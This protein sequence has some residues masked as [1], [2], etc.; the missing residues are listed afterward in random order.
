MILTIFPDR[1]FNDHRTPPQTCA[2]LGI[3]MPSPL[4]VLHR[5]HG[6]H[7]DGVRQLYGFVQV[8]EATSDEWTQH[9]ELS[10]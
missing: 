4:D 1:T 9:S 3:I 10:Y 8:A 5:L 2:A 7:I 6:R